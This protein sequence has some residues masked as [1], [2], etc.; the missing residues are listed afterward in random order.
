MTLL[1]MLVTL[2][3]VAILTTI[4]MQAMSQIRRVEQM[5]QAGQLSAQSRLLRIEW[6]RAAIDSAL[7]LPAN[8]PERWIGADRSLIFST[9]QAPGQAPGSV[10]PLRL[11]LQYDDR[12][13]QTRLEVTSLVPGAEAAPWAVL[14]WQGSAGCLRYLDAMG[15]WHDQWPPPLAAYVGLPVTVALD[16]QTPGVPALVWATGVSAT[17]EA[18]R[19]SLEGL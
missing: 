14:T 11:T 4:L 8:A 7:P 2:A 9:T 3:L 18:A 12:T 15:N 16:P 6:L 13:A 1:E 10:S 5:L 19:R 17:P